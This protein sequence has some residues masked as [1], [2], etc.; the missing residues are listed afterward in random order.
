MLNKV[1]L[2]SFT[3]II[4]SAKGWSLSV[5]RIKCEGGSGFYALN[6][7]SHTWKASV[8]SIS[9]NDF[10][11]D[12]KHLS[13]YQNYSKFISHYLFIS[14]SMLDSVSISSLRLITGKF[15]DFQ[16]QAGKIL[17][18]N[19]YRISVRFLSIFLSRAFSESF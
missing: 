18:C 10:Y 3:S 4:V 5:F 8:L 12:L 19:C 11:V 9:S 17:L 14:W 15:P 7:F 2:T 16:K 13:R 6:V 1:L